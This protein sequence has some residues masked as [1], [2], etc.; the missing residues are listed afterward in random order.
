MQE[1]TVS[2]V[3]KYT[4]SEKRDFIRRHQMEFDRRTQLNNRA[5][6]LIIILMAFI[7]A[8]SYY[9]RNFPK[10]EWFW[11]FGLFLIGFM[12]LSI[13]TFVAMCCILGRSP[14]HLSSSNPLKKESRQKGFFAFLLGI[15]CSGFPKRFY[16]RADD[17]KPFDYV[18]IRKERMANNLVSE[19]GEEEGMDQ[20]IHA[21][22]LRVV[23]R[24]AVQN[25]YQEDRIELAKQWI[26]V[27]LVGLIFA[28]FTHLWIC[29][30]D[31]KST[32]ESATTNLVDREAGL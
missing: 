24:D 6:S 2:P 19:L 12:A 8:I 10:F 16:Q 26:L 5:N 17:V 13:A 23:D 27:A 30:H 18:A 14:S 28:A 9:F 29:N 20:L 7:G 3:C 11:G 21:E 1:A 22:Y 15:V 31:K 25:K 32:V 4:N